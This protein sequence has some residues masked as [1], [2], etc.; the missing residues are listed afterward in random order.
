MSDHR[1]LRSC[2]NKFHRLTDK[3]IYWNAYSSDS[4]LTFEGS[5]D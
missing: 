1:M 3:V 2:F 5:R 4:F